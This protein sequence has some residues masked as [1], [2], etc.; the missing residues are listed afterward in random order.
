MRAGRSEWPK[1]MVL[2]TVETARQTRFILSKNIF[3]SK[4]PI[5]TDYGNTNMILP[6][7]PRE[8]VCFD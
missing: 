5:L 8:I 3:S 1:L 2:P 4:Q 6:W 7:F